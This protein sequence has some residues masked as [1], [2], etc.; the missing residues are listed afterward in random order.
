MYLSPNLQI[1]RANTNVLTSLSLIC[2]YRETALLYNNKTSSL[3]NRQRVCL[4]V[5][6]ELAHQVYLCC[7]SVCLFVPCLFVPCLC[8]PCL[9]FLCLSVSVCLCLSVCVCLS[10]SV[11]VLYL[12]VPCPCVPCPG[13][14]ILCSLSLCCMSLFLFLL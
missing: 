2:R 7:L 1:E 14:L 10:V 8:V 6:H 5:A 9:H 4:V 3:G 13:L 12:C 11:C